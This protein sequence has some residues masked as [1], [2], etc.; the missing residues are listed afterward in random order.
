MTA[1]SRR[2]LVTGSRE[3]PDHRQV[4]DELDHLAEVLAPGDTMTVVHGDARGADRAASNWCRQ[5][6]NTSGPTVIE[7]PHAANWDECGPECTRPM[8]KRKDGTLFCP[9]AGTRRN[10][11][12]VSLGADLCLAFP[13]TANRSDSPGTWDCLGKAAAARIPYR[14]MYPATR[15]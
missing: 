11:D 10:A 1:I 2:V 3:W 6:R 7:E 15:R 8:R 4:W 5:R 9:E 13:L 14:R 12:M